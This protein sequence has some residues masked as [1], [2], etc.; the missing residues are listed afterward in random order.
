MLKRLFFLTWFNFIIYHK[1]VLPVIILLKIILRK[2]IQSQNLMFF[3]LSPENCSM[4]DGHRPRGNI[5]SGFQNSSVARNLFGTPS[6]VSSPSGYQTPP[7]VSN[8]LAQQN[9]PMVVR[10][11]VGYH[12][13]IVAR[14]V[15]MN[16]DPFGISNLFESPNLFRNSHA[17]AN[18]SANIPRIR[19][20]QKLPIWEETHRTPLLGFYSEFNKNAPVLNNALAPNEIPNQISIPN[21]GNFNP[22]LQPTL[23]NN[24]IFHQTNN[25]PVIKPKFELLFHKKNN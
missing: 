12:T 24:D 18:Q 8:P 16:P 2:S 17:N 4:G 1:F 25:S 22:P 3:A 6:I 20:A 21:N 9:P 19:L 10:N 14:N 15:P 11:L 23:T 13:S 7:A 5:G